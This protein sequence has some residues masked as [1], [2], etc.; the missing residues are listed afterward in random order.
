MTKSII[1]SRTHPQLKINTT[2]P[3]SVLVDSEDRQRKNMSFTHERCKETIPIF[4]QG[5]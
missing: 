2:N 3:I 4:S 1:Y 5:N